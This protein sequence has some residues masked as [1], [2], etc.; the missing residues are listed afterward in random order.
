MVPVVVDVSD[1]RRVASRDLVRVPGGAL[2]RRHHRPVPRVRAHRVDRLDR[3]GAHQHDD[4]VAGRA[5]TG[6]T[7]NLRTLAGRTQHPAECDGLGDIVA[8]C[9]LCAQRGD[10]GE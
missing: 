4:V 1:A 10:P 7:Q 2:D 9:Q 3:R 8:V 5:D 6:T